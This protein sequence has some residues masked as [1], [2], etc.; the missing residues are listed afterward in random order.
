MNR[1][2]NIYRT[3]ELIYNKKI[4]EYKKTYDIDRDMKRF[5][6]FLL[7]QID[8]HKPEEDNIKIMYFECELPLYVQTIINNDDE[9]K[10]NIINVIVSSIL[11]LHELNSM[12][13]SLLI[14]KRNNRLL[15]YTEFRLINYIRNENSTINDIKRFIEDII[16]NKEHDFYEKMDY[17]LMEII[18]IFRMYVKKPM[19][20]DDL[21]NTHRYV[22]KV[23]KNGSKNMYFY[24]LHNQEHSLELIRLSISIVKSIGFFKIKAIDYYILF[25][26]CYL[27]DISMVIQP[28]DKIFLSENSKSNSILTDWIQDIIKIDYCDN[29]TIKNVIL[30][31]Y[32]RIEQFFE[33][34][35]RSKHGDNSCDF[36]KK[37]SSMNF[38]E[39]SIKDIVANISASH[40]YD[41]T[42]IYSLKSK[43]KDDLI[44]KKTI[45]ILLRLADLLDMSKDRVSTEIMD[46]NMEQMPTISR[47]H[48]ISHSIINSCNI[49][50]EY[51]FEENG[52]TTN[53]FL[54]KDFF[55][56]NIFLDIKLNYFNLNG[57][58]DYKKCEYASCVEFQAANIKISFTKE[59]CTGKCNFICKWMCKKNEW[60]MKEFYA[61]Q[62]Y[63]NRNN[64]N[65]F[66]TNFYIN[67]IYDEKRELKREYYDI[68]KDY[69]EKD[70][71]EK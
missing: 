18:H 15:T 46:I 28:H 23:W 41:D 68:I 16:T 47:F 21:I 34:E 33:N 10:K 12:S 58:K 2:D 60:L 53:T 8:Y 64:G 5:L 51:K 57:L 62:R 35:V 70:I 20:I 24:T 54:R 38:I 1:H 48:W 36:I 17:S 66:N 29:S 71:E 59:Q 3:I 50:S 61:L 19:Y 40:L 31:Y 49:R 52:E 6:K 9:F 42:D 56:E 26:A 11:N 25:L 32:K 45:M 14:K 39:S 13:E 43:G 30:S 4:Q 69:I 7:S 63:I 37:T 67:L 65:N 27:H 55:H 22:T 44:N